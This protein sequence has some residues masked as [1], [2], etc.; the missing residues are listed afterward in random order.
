MQTGNLEETVE[1]E[2]FHNL[3]FTWYALLDS[4]SVSAST[5]VDAGPI[6]STKSQ[7]QC[8]PVLCTVR[9]HVN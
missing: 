9:V 7:K 2:E 4:I 1:S 8:N 5:Q 6:A 3:E